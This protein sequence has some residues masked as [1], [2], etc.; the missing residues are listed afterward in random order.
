MNKRIIPGQLVYWQNKGA[1]VYELKGLSEAI[2][3]TIDGESTELV[4]VSDLTVSLQP[5][6]K[7]KTTHLDAQQE[8]WNAAIKRYETIKPLLENPNRS[9]KDIESI[10]KSSGVSVPTLYRWMKKYSETGLVSS[11][12]RPA[13]SD[14]GGVR[15]DPEQ[16]A[17]ISKHIESF[18]LRKERPN[19]PQLFDRIA[20]NCYE[21]DIPAPHINTVYRRINNLD[22]HMAVKKRL[23][24]K[25]AKQ[26]FQPLRGSFPGA[27]FPNAV[28][29]VDHTKA[30]IIVVDEQHRLPIGR[31]YLTIA[32]DVAT[33]MIS[34]FRITLDPPGASSAGLCIAHAITRKEHWL[35]QR[36]IHAEWP[37]YGK[38]EKLH[39]DNAKEFRGLMLERACNEYGIIIE[40]RPKGQPN[41]GPHVERAFRTFMQQKHSLPGTTFSSVK[42][43]L[44]YDSEGLAC[45]TLSELETWFTVFVVYYYH[46]KPHRGNNNIPPIELYNRMILGDENHPGIGLPQPITD[47]ETLRLH[48]TPYFE[49]TIQRDGVVVDHIKYYSPILRK[50]INA[51]DPE[52][53]DKTRKFIFA[54]DPRD[55]SQLYFWDPDTLTYAPIPYFNNTRPAISIWE[56]QAILKQQQSGKTEI[57]EEMIFTGIAKMRDIEE[58]AIEKT[59]LAKQQ[60]ATE[61]RKR[62]MAARRSHWKNIHK[63]SA[64]EHPMVAVSN[65]E[66]EAMDILPFSDIQIEE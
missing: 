29:Q 52:Q 36:D 61:K 58:E 11:L 25:S 2:I 35:A 48:F 53:P 30:D 57:N 51:K 47:E 14:K 32:I 65:Q 40:H 6:R 27:N 31:P 60:R 37:I 45:M 5:E 39:M 42:D 12:L 21:L 46:H 1:V 64:T 7:Q 28:V 49:R 50:W 23:G 33:K 22:E 63:E 38:M 15:I 55:I 43:K 19:I 20:A 10:A 54:R 59:R 24:V 13:R 18:Y 41:Y 44:D 4:P 66:Q 16:E 62:R 34:G 17:I 26:M 56:L 9:A 3:R 8:E